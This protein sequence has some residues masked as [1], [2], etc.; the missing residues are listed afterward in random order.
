M[1]IFWMI[2]NLVMLSYYSITAIFCQK[3]LVIMWRRRWNALFLC[4]GIPFNNCF[5]EPF[6]NYNWPLH[7]SEQYVSDGDKAMLL[8]VEVRFTFPFAVA[9][10][11]LMKLVCVQYRGIVQINELHYLIYGSSVEFETTSI[12]VETILMLNWKVENCALRTNT[13]ST[14][15]EEMADFPCWDV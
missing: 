7:V 13:S 15:D 12:H 8:W 11:G 6:Y 3:C 14:K 1:L 4:I 5:P 2:L 9:W 10:I